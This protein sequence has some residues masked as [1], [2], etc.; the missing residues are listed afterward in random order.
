M[1]IL[2]ERKDHLIKKHPRFS[3]LT[4]EE[5]QYLITYFSNR[6]N[7]PN[8]TIDWNKLSDYDIHE[9]YKA[10]Q[11]LSK[12]GKEKIVKIKGIQGLR[13][14]KDYLIF[15]MPSPYQ[16]FI[17]LTYEASKLIASKYIGPCEGDWCTAYQKTIKY[18]HGYT[19]D[20]KIVLIYVI[21][22]KTKYALTIGETKKVVIFDA[23]D[24]TVEISAF[25]KALG[26]DVEA[27]VSQNDTIVK[28]AQSLLIANGKLLETNLLEGKIPTNNYFL[29]RFLKNQYDLSR[30]D[31]SNITS[32]AYLFKGK[33]VPQYIANWNVSNVE[34]MEGM[35]NG[36]ILNVDLSKWKV[37]KVKNM[38]FMFKGASFTANIASWDVSNVED[39][40]FMF[41]GATFNEDLSMWNPR[42]VKTMS[43][44]FR[45]SQFN[46]DISKWNVSNVKDM[47]YLF[48]D[49]K[50]NGNI[51]K[52]NVSNVLSM[53]FMF[54]SSP[55]NGDISRWNTS[56][57]GTM[58][59]MFA[60]SKFNGDISKWDVSN[61]TDMQLMFAISPFNQDISKWDVSNVTDMHGMFANSLFNQDIHQ[62]NIN[63]EALSNSLNIFWG[64][65]LE[66]K[67]P[68]GLRDLV[69]EQ[70]RSRKQESFN[71][72][73]DYLYED[74]L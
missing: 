12:T 57:V 15:P 27:I 35:F 37:S 67:Y 2:F 13:E 50:F 73:A 44:M 24:K 68:N 22:K 60:S 45:Y 46:G 69:A 10:T 41:Y 39:M 61:V 30:I 52:W 48:S 70:Q 5:Q 59:A 6:D 74:Y 26:V 65:P 47:S 9:L 29:H 53:A 49:S 3:T 58:K 62:W 16:A 32:M 54:R 14:E 28:K 20:Y 8:L 33:I 23:K 18:W 64:S 36:A 56:Q 40:E 7:P 71:S 25:N 17:P 4:P 1:N 34:N 51:S 42:K 63:Q 31:T 38:S 43:G 19:Y 11:E 72:L 55:F 66:Q 21:T